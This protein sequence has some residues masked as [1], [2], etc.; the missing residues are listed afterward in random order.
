MIDLLPETGPQEALRVGERVREAIE[1]LALPYKDK[2]GE[3]LVRCTA[4]IGLATFP[5]PSI[6]SAEALIRSAD[7]CLY[8]AKEG[9]RNRV[10]QH[11]E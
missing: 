8:E 1:R 3:K 2:E 5:V 4:S 9:G 10:R 6:D 7:D 11:Q